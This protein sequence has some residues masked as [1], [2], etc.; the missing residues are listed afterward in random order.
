MDRNRDCAVRSGSILARRRKLK[1]TAA[2]DVPALPASVFIVWHRFN[3]PK[4]RR[5]YRCGFAFDEREANR[6]AQVAK[7]ATMCDDVKVKRY[8]DPDPEG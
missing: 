6:Q 3:D 7:V 4:D 2:V 5:W 1:Q 8:D